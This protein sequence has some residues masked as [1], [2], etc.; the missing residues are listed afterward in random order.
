[1]QEPLTRSCRTA[2]IAF[3]A[4]GIVAVTP[5]T[6][7]LP[8]STGPPAVALSTSYVDLFTNTMDN[9][10]NIG[11]NT[12][13]SAIS[14]VF[15][16]LF[17]NPSGVIDAVS[18]FT[19][20]VD[21][22]IAALP[23][24]VSV[25]LSPALEMLIAGLASK[26]ATLDAVYGVVADLG[27]PETA[28]TALFNAPA[29]V[30]DA[31]LNGQ[32]NLPL[33]GGIINIPVYHGIL[34]PEQNLE[35][36]LDLS[37]LLDL[38]GLGDLD[39]SN[40]DLDDVI[41]HVRLGTLTVGGLLSSLGIG[42]DG[43]GD[44]L[45]LGGNVSDLGGLLDFLGLGDFGLGRY[46]LPVILSELGLDPAILRDLDLNLDFDSLR[47]VD[48]LNAFGID[49]EIPLGL[50][51]LLIGLGDGSLADEQLGSLLSNVGLLSHVVS[52]LN[53]TVADALDP[54]PLVGPL[55]TSLVNGLLGSD[56]VA[57]VLNNVTIGDLLGDLHIDESVGSLL[58]ALGGAALSA[59]NLTVGGILQDLGFAE[60]TGELTLNDL[61]GGLG[62]GL[63]GLDIT[64]LLNGL[65]VGGLVGVLGLDNLPLD[66]GDVI[67]DWASPNVG[68]LLQELVQG[69]V[70]L[71]GASV[72]SFG[73]MI[74]ELFVSV[75][76]HILAMLGG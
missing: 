7:P 57:A 43:L 69:Q 6:L 9:V 59:S 21:T 18:N 32:Y 8:A 46:T 24:T 39:L 20:V 10:R 60:S 55:L 26:V 37:R 19:M 76:Q 67:R 62:G 61:F 17:S 38:L 13:W 48:V 65:D 16:A 64:G 75:P 14:Q 23:A 11:A 30:L 54:I 33:L 52:G 51:Q 22:D 56:G 4:A 74:T 28:F 71:A 15:A 63:L 3:A 12:D 29:T 50:G 53:A 41:E 1:M 66:F 36:E 2:G 68:E 42:D 5:V 25:Q 73:G 58:A 31:Y 45:K 35:V 44:L 70:N 49:A 47:L 72:G 27:N 34:A 40:A